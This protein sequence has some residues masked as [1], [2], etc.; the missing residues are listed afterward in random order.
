MASRAAIESLT[1][2]EGLTDSDLG[3]NSFPKK[4][5]APKP[6]KIATIR[7]SQN[8]PFLL[9]TNFK[10]IQLN[11]IMMGV[12]TSKSN[13]KRHKITIDVRCEI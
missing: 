13:H 9:D 2:E 11:P 12:A 7:S 5:D 1:L 10:A 4:K 3:K 6:S 8:R